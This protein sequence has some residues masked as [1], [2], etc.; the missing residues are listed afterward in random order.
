LAVLAV[1][2]N[3]VTAWSWFGVN[4]MGVGLHAYGFRSGMVF[5]LTVFV[6]SQL[7]IMVAGSMSSTTKVPEPSQKPS[8]G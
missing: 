3:V 5:W 4:A 7:A 6:A 1:F 2:G 8:R